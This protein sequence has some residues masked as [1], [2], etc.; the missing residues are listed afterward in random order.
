[1]KEFPVYMDECNGTKIMI[2]QNRDV[3][4]WDVY[5]KRVNFPYKYVFGLSCDDCP[6]EDA[7]EIAMENIPYYDDIFEE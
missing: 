4:T 2:L 1:M 5:F 3:F 7:F 6:L